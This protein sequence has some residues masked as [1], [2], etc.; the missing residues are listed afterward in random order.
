MRAGELEALRTTYVD[1]VHGFISVTKAVNRKSGKV[2]PTKTE[3]TGDVPI[4]PALAPLLA[5][6][7][8]GRPESG[9]VLWLPPDEDRAENL[10]KHLRKAGI[11]RAALYANDARS[12]RSCSTTSGRRAS[13]GGRSRGRGG[14]SSRRSPGTLSFSTTLGSR[15]RHAPPESVASVFAAAARS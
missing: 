4:E 10:R 15:R 12:K 1:L 8:E 13:P 3:E 7:K 9:H 6:M 5:A 14:V 11:T 2:G